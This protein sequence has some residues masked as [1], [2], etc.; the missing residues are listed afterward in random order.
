MVMKVEEKIIRL[1][2]ILKNNITCT[3]HYVCM[4]YMN[5]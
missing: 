1:F 4:Y 2:F 5:V 3:V